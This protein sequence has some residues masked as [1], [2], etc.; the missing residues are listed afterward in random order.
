M[1]QTI[2]S[3]K[4]FILYINGPVLTKIIS[5]IILFIVINLKIVKTIFFLVIISTYIQHNSLSFA[6]SGPQ[7]LNIYSVVLYRKGLLISALDS[8]IV[9]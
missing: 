4:H 8:F 2:Y 9:L 5:I 7:I 3:P 1:K 6:F